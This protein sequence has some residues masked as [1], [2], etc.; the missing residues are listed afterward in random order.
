LKRVR[1]LTAPLSAVFLIVIAGFAFTQLQARTE[2]PP[3]ILDPE[4]NLWVSSPELGG[5]KPMVWELEY[6]KSVGD[7]ILLQEAVMGDKQALGIQ[8]FQDG[9]DENFTYVRLGQTIDGIRARALFDEEVGIWVLLQG[10]CACSGRASGQ[11]VTFEI[12]TNDGTHTLDFLLAE[13]T[14]EA[15]VSPTH[16]T[17]SLQT[18]I[19]EWTHHPIDI[20]KQYENAQWKL[21][22]RISLSIVFGVPGSAG[23]WHSEYVHGFSVAKRTTRN[24]TQQDEIATSP[25][26]TTTPD[27]LREIDQC[28]MPT[29]EAY[30]HVIRS[31]CTSN[32]RLSQR[33]NL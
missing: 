9:T 7:Q 17:I 30:L 21:P 13:T 26:A 11:T 19:G 20:A 5:N 31:P 29:L 33:F 28:A 24:L 22:D 12:E 10:S 32:A 18:P 15:N 25:P 1:Q 6:Q 14:A 2:Y 3:P 8:I 16:R 4:F 23:G 27:I